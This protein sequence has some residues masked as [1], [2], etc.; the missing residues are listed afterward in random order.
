[1]MFKPTTM[2]ALLTF[3]A[4][5]ITASPLDNRATCAYTCGSVCYYQSDVDA[6][7]T[8]GYNYYEEGE[9]VGS[10]D[11]PHTEN[12]YEDI[13]FYVSGPYQEFPILS[14]YKVYTGGSPGADR[15]VFN[16]DGDLA[17]VVTHTGASG[18]DFVPCDGCCA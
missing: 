16:T 14:S 8:Q 1:M 13:D 15:V 3:V 4:T 2:L 6:A 12:N 5:T 18:D 11:Y 9:Q 7:V 10:N 17:G